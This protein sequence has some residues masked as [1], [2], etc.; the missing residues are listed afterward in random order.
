MADAV[1]L[2]GDARALRGVATA[3]EVACVKAAQGV[4]GGFLAHQR[5]LN[6]VPVS[7]SPDICQAD[8]RA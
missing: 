6:P 7:S 1:L 4:W 8:Q 5:L 3:Q 2:A